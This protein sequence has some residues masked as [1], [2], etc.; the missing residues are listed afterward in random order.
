MNQ[1]VPEPAPAVDVSPASSRRTRVFVSYSR[2]DLPFAQLLVSAL[3]E[4]GFE[5]FLDKTDIAPGEPWQERLAGLIAAADTVVF[6]ISP[7]SVASTICGWELE[8]SARLSKRLIPVVARRIPDADAPPQLGRLNWIFCTENDSRD[9]ALA[10]LDTALRTDLQWVREHTRL[11]EL[12]RRWDENGR[13]KTATLRGADL[14]AAESWLDRRPADANAPTDLH[15]EFIRASRRAATSRQRYW[16]GGSIAV[17]VMAIGLA[18]FAEVNRREAQAE[19]VIAQEQRDRAEHTLALATGTANGLI[20]DLAQKFR[21]V[22]GVPAATVKDILDRARQLQEQLLGSGESNPTLRRSQAGAL[23]ESAI[24]LLAV[25]DT[26][27]ALA[28]ATQAHDILQTLSTQQPDNK[29]FQSEFALSIE[30]IAD[31]YKE[32]GRLQDALQSYQASVAIY[33]KLV[34]AS[35]DALRWQRS[36]E[37]LDNRIATI[38]VAQ[39]HLPEA[40]QS[41]G[42]ALAIA[43]RLAKSDPAN[44]EWQRDLTVAYFHVG[45][46][47]DA[48]GKLTEALRSYR[49]ALANADALAK[50]DRRNGLWQG[51]LAT[52]NEKIGDVQMRAGHLTEALRAYQISLDVRRD[53]AISDP[54]NAGWQFDLAT[55][56]ER[57]GDVRKTMG[58]LSGAQQAYRASLDIRD[59]LVK[60]D[61]ANTLWLRNLA[62][63]HG[64]LGDLASA[65]GD[66]KAALQSYRAARDIA[67][68]LGKID[69]GNSEWQRDIALNTTSVG[70]ALFAADDLPGALQA[71]QAALDIAGKLAGRDQSNTEWQRDLAIALGNV[72][73]VLVKLGRLDEALQSQNAS[74][75]I[76]VRLAG[77]D[78]GNVQWQRDLE[79]GY[80]GVGDVLLAQ[81]NFS[82]ALKSYQSQ[83]ATAELLIKLDADNPEAR[84]DVAVAHE[85]VGRAQSFLGRL[86]EALQSYRSALSILDRL[87]ASHPDNGLWRNSLEYN[88]RLIGGLAYGLVLA[89]DFSLALEAADQVIAKT[90]SMIDV[91]ANRAHALMFLG[92]TDEARAIYLRYRAEQ[93]LPG[94]RSWDEVVLEDFAELRKAGL[95]RPLMDEIE[96]LFNEKHAPDP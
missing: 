17:A 36:I 49:S 64:K 77:S 55:G 30:K 95:T 73:N 12:A 23:I 27:G 74:L 54:S 44:S 4:R 31:A 66:D 60:S 3:D 92:R 83:L 35:P 50:S 14:D 24:T 16:V 34:A 43:D 11:G 42:E 71:Y 67:E 1:H 25:G 94:H 39:G 32:Q 62:V 96:T 6:V 70:D 81:R 87:V 10:L 5:A 78:R 68:R 93:D 76:D 7:D 86:P 19:R 91:Y 61:P 69:P 26:K 9:A 29:D 21:N 65:Q 79:V 33:R 89:Q 8:E 59:K 90:P 57:L 15:Q 18:V 58:Q 40:V 47:L 56:Y 38:L 84:R 20:Y 2:K 48:Q 13:S 75:A 46:T 41:Y 82:E 63:A 72:G 28:S 52:A 80:Q 22:V 53:L 37:V 88:M 85:K 45:E 51:D